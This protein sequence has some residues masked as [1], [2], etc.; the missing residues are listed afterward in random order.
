M[1]EQSI[2]NFELRGN[3]NRGPPLLNFMGSVLGNGKNVNGN[4]AS[5]IAL[6]VC[7]SNQLVMGDFH[8]KTLH[9]GWREDDKKAPCTCGDWRSNETASFMDSIGYGRKQNL[10]PY[11]KNA[12]DTLTHQCPRVSSSN[13]SFINMF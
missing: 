13:P 7:R 10:S 6:P 8:H 2:E 3:R 12:V 11:D 9:V 1:R 5:Q 4:N